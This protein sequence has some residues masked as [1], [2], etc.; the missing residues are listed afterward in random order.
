MDTPKRRLR[1][2]KNKSF[3]RHRKTLTRSRAQRDSA[4]GG[5]W[6]VIRPLLSTPILSPS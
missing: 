3:F 1:K 5:F 2:Q 4:T 6:V